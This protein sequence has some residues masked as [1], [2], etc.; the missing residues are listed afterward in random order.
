MEVL[1]SGSEKA[2][3]FPENSCKNRNLD[4]TGVILPVFPFR[5]NLKLHHIFVTPK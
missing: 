5:T 1:S 4:E 3:L 2:K